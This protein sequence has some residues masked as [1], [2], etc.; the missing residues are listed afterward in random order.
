MERQIVIQG[1]KIVYFFRRSRRARR[2]SL[3]VRRGGEV[4]LTL[5]W[6]GRQAEGEKFIRDKATWV[7][8]QLA[9]FQQRGHSPLAKVTA[10]DYVSN[11]MAAQCLVESRVAYFN[12]FYQLPVAKITIKNQKTRWGSCS[13]R[14]NLNF[15]F[16]LLFLPPELADYI[17][18]HE[19][20]H[21]REMNHSPRFWAL[22]SKTLPHHKA[23][24]RELRNFACS[25]L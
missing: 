5:P 1:Q 16:R 2:L 19:L 25:L 8:K 20:C 24:R 17:I 18:V 22:V 14:S 10:A 9:V 23:M 4:V 7:L 13:R 3:S 11:K 6:F 12:K 15:N 21:L